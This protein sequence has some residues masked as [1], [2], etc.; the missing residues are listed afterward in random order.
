MK[1][2]V[3]LT[4]N[5]ALDLSAAAALVVPTEKVRCHSSRRDPGGGGI[6]VARVIQRLG[7]EVKAIFPAGGLAG[8]ALIQLLEQEAV[9]SRVI[10]IAGETR[11]DVTILDEQADCQ[12]RFI[13]PG[14]KLSEREWLAC[15]SAVE[16]AGACFACASGSLP[17]GVPQDFYERFAQTAHRAGQK[18]FLDTSGEALAEA[19][20]APVSVIKPNLKELRALVGSDLGSEGARIKVCQQ[21]LARSKL[22]AIALTL[23]ADGA[24]LVTQ[25]TALRA[26]PPLIQPASTVGA[27]DSFMGALIWAL[28]ADMGFAEALRFGV[29]AG[30][31]AVLCEGTELCHAPDIR[32]IEREVT[33]TQLELSPL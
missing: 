12:Y 3:T 31:A 25:K 6:N 29:A 17:P 20:K 10:G 5:P 16:K 11:E 18:V 14:P 23:G 26:K 7:G 33:L 24:L 22:E 30:T 32:R 1:P 28:A 21:L 8:E 19:L 2:V 15:L 9:E 13:L 27:G 4:V